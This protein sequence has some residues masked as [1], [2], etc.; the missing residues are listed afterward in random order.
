MEET[1]E[2]GR[3]WPRLYILIE[4]WN[5]A[6]CACRGTRFWGR[7]Y[8]RDFDLEEGEG[9][10]QRK[11]AT[12]KLV[13]KI[14]DSRDSQEMVRIKKRK[15]E[16]GRGGGKTPLY[17]QRQKDHE[18]KRNSRGAL[19]SD[20]IEGH[21][22]LGPR[23]ERIQETQGDRRT[24]VKIPGSMGTFREQG[25]HQDEGHGRDEADNV[26]LSQPNVLP[27]AGIFLLSALRPPIDNDEQGDEDTQ[28]QLRAPDA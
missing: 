11:V 9:R 19:A 21:R 28:H 17:P 14:H 7:S 3:Q 15:R 10:I 27:G 18:T 5:L 24:R 4:G 8:R 16:R 12:L 2:E 26:G 25:V 23:D 1:K 22:K 6:E 20:K 13:P